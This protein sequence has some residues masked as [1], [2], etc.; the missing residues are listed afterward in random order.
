MVES[1]CSAV[2]SPQ[3]YF[4]PLWQYSLLFCYRRIILSSIEKNELLLNG[5]LIE[6]KSPIEQKYGH[7]STSSNINSPYSSTCIQGVFTFNIYMLN[8][9]LPRI[10][11][12]LFHLLGLDD[13]LI[14]GTIHSFIQHHMNPTVVIDSEDTKMNKHNPCLL[15]ILNSNMEWD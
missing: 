2:F 7:Q 9:Y 4:A 13:L 10:S 8:I 14:L 3:L 1:C 6:N 15:K 11:H 12:L 5:V